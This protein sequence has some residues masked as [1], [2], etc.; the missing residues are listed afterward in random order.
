M[1]KF[2]LLITC[3]ISISI[4]ILVVVVLVFFGFDNQTVISGAIAGGVAGA[5]S[6]S[7]L[8]KENNK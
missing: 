5:I 4:A 2:S 1:R 7:F 3:L 6:T 8:K